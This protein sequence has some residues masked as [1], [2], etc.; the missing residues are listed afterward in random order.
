MTR[1]TRQKIAILEE[2]KGRDKHPTAD[3]VYRAVRRRL[4]DISLGTV[5]RNLDRLSRGGLIRT[6]DGPGSRRY[7]GKLEDHSHARCLSCGKI[8]NVEAGLMPV[9]NLPITTGDGFRVTDF[10]IE[11]SG[12]CIKCVKEGA[13]DLR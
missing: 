3:E 11:F 4:P 8:G 1:M 12:L 7:D 9:L 6:L 5:Y 13:Q 2:L 10:R